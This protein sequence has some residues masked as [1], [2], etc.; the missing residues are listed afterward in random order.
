MPPVAIIS[1][2]HANLSALRTVLTDIHDQKISRI[3]CLGDLVGYFTEP[4]PVIHLILARCEIVIKGN[5]DITAITGD[6]PEYYRDQSHQPLTL[7]HHLLTVH[8]RK[9]LNDL[10]TQVT[11]QC[12]NKKLMLIHGGPEYPYDQYIYPD[13][14]E[15]LQSTFSFM[16][17]LEMDV[18]FLGHTHIPFKAELDGR[19]ICNP[20]SVGQPRDGDARASYAIYD[21]QNDLVTFRRITYDPTQTIMKVQELL[22]TAMSKDLVERLLVGR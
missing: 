21:A 2:I 6:I 13:D 1:D 22:P 8:E 12:G 19:M 18:L 4:I 10:P 20:G 16:K 9:I 5:N 11:V 14:E 7:T 17:M 15:D 3:F